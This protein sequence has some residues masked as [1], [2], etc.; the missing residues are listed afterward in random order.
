ML[1][2]ST[3]LGAG[4][5]M[6]AKARCCTALSHL[7]DAAQAIPLEL[8]SVDA[9]QGGQGLTA[10]KPCAPANFRRTRACLLQSCMSLRQAAGQACCRLFALA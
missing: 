10:R 3:C 6:R 4:A 8:A 1:E 2:A 5:A 9:Q 7:L